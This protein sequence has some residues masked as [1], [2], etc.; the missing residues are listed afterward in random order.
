[1]PKI[2]GDGKSW[3]RKSKLYK[4]VVE[5]CKKK[6]KGG[7]YVRLT[8]LPPSCA[9]CHEI[10]EPQPPVTL[11]A[12]PGLEWDCFTL[13][14]IIAYRLC[15]IVLNRK[16]SPEF[17][18][19]PKFLSDVKAKSRRTRPACTSPTY[20]NHQVV[21]FEGKIFTIILH[22]ETSLVV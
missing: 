20:F 3:L 13:Y 7:R 22:N 19:W 10:W 12:R 6:K 17:E 5:L 16:L 11:R 18:E 4:G 21:M 15:Q 9:V 1:M 8:N 14:P 2:E